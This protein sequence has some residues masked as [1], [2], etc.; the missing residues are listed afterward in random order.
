MDCSWGPNQRAASVSITFDHFGEAAELEHGTWPA[1]EQIGNHQSVTEILPAVLQALESHDVRGT[2]YVEAWNAEHYP[3]QLRDISARGHEVACHSYRHENWELL[4][5]ADIDELLERCMAAY[6]D[7]GLSVSGVRPPG[8]I[9]P[10]GYASV[11]GKHGLTYVSIAE[12]HAGVAAGLGHVPFQWRT[13]DGAY[14]TDYFAKLRRPPGESAVSVQE[15]LAAWEEVLDDTAAAGAHCSFVLHLPWQDSEERLD[16]IRRLA[17]RLAADDRLWVATAGEVSDW[18]R[19][20]PELFPYRDPETP[21]RAWTP[22]EIA[23]A[24]A[25]S[26][27]LVSSGRDA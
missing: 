11:V 24:A 14:Y 1:D 17:E 8:G 16:G 22:E 13:V 9:P 23:Q 6:G 5:L 7:A 27:S 25:L 15:M 26:P 21:R 3:A 12:D 18:M 19:S 20:N 2:F 4:A 10:V